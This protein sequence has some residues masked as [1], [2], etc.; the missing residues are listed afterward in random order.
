[1][2]IH[3]SILAWRR[4]RRA[5]QATVHGV[6]RTRA[7]AHTHPLKD[8]LLGIPW[9][10]SGQESALSLLRA[11]IQ[12]LVGELIS[13]CC[14]AKKT[15]NKNRIKVNSLKKK[16][17]LLNHQGLGFPTACLFQLSENRVTGR[18]SDLGQQQETPNGPPV[19]IN[20]RQLYKPEQRI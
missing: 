3:S 11:G 15:T 16:I 20:T 9:Q 18:L 7:R 13:P 19:I 2:Q 14:V 6:A 8:I 12:S 4:D 10:S 1:M 5:W 17:S